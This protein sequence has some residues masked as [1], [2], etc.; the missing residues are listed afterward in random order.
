L[1]GAEGALIDATIE[2]E[3]RTRLPEKPDADDP[4][5][6]QPVGAVKESFEQ[7]LAKAK[8]DRAAWIA[9]I[10]G[11]AARYPGET[12]GWL[13]LADAR[14]VAEEF[15]ACAAAADRALAIDPANRRAMVR[16]AQAAISLAATLPADQRTAAVR[17][18][19]E[20]LLKAI[21][22]DPDDPLPAFLF[23]ASFAKQGRPANADGLQ[24]LV[25]TV[26]LIPQMPEPRL[27]LAQELIQRGR[28]KDARTILRPLANSPHQNAITRRA[29]A[30]LDDIETKLGSA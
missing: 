4:A 24:A 8:Q 6:K 22:L 30:L 13:L 26:Q 16:K 17:A 19:Q 23:Y 29:R 15:A 14:C 28:L 20:T 21:D 27:I 3:R 1:G 10:G 11:I 25:N 12:A 9:Q 2:F 18:G 7:R 5:D